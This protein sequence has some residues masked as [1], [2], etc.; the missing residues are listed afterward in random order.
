MGSHFDIASDPF[1]ILILGGAY[2]GLAAAL[3]LIDLSE[4]RAARTG[5][6]VLPG[7]DGKVP[8][9]VTIVDERDGYCVLPLPSVSL[10]FSTSH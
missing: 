7:H 1:R 9:D 4:G 10:L 8:I 6:G 2:G 5:N 3:N